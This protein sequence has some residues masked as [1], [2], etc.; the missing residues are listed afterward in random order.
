MF[1]LRFILKCE[2][3]ILQTNYLIE[4]VEKEDFI[5]NTITQYKQK[6]YHVFSSFKN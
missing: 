3:K 6:I 4:D 2:A 1:K 5:K